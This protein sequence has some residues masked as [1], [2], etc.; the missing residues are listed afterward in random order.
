MLRL[1]ITLLATVVASGCGGPEAYSNRS[2]KL[3]LAR[4]SVVPLGA[5]A[6]PIVEVDLGLGVPRR[7]LID[8][9]AESSCVSLRCAAEPALVKQSLASPIR[10][11]GSDGGSIDVT[12]AAV[13]ERL[14]VAELVVRPARLLVVDGTSFT[15][16]NIDGIIGMD[17]LARIVTIVDMQRRQVHLLPEGGL[18]R[19]KDYLRVAKIGDGQWPSGVLEFTPL[20]LVPFTVTDGGVAT[21]YHLTLDTG[22]VSS[23]LPRPAIAAMGLQPIRKQVHGGVGG[24]Y[25]ADVYRVEGFDMFGFTLGFDASASMREHGMLGMDILGS[26]VLVV[27]G[28]A[29]TVWLHHRK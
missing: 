19:V 25:E 24:T 27:D 5:D 10:M 28:P 3:E 1:T 20:P 4:A 13:V 22:A 23:G 15:D 18:E 7:F 9:G 11:M 29:R 6:R 21:K 14:A 8:T 12:E 2:A 26:L 16:A 17:L